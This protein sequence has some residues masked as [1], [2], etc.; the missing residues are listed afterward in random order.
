MA[1]N[2]LP[3]TASLYIGINPE[4]ITQGSIN[5]RK[6]LYLRGRLRSAAV[7]QPVMQPVD[8][9]VYSLVRNLLHLP[10]VGAVH[11]SLYVDE[12]S[13]VY[14]IAVQWPSMET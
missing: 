10:D 4:N 6:G 12:I 3:N 1:I 11:A 7:Y 5:L 2:K 13:Y 14:G 8:K 9:P